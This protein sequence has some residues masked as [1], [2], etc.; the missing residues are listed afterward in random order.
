MIDAIELTWT[1]CLDGYEV[2]EVPT[3]EPAAASGGL[4]G[5]LVQTVGESGNNQ[6]AGRSLEVAP[7]S[8]EFSTYR[9]MEEVQRQSVDLVEEFAN[10]THDPLAIAG[11]YERFGPLR[12]P[13]NGDWHC[14]ESLRSWDE[15]VPHWEELQG[16]VRQ[17][18]LLLEKGSHRE[19]AD[20]FETGFGELTLRLPWQR[21]WDRP[22]MRLEPQDLATLIWL[23]AGRLVAGNSTVRPCKVCSKLMIIGGQ[24]GSYSNRET[25]SD[26]CRYAA[27]R[28]GKK[29]AKAG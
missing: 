10:T 21:A 6:S 1:R 11:F 16:N 4:L 22:I 28:A 24:T 27:Y 26:R 2:R 17:V 29:R 19:A 20:M 25:C 23:L 14:P 7:L 3:D 8:G 15:L 13:P 9:V 5:A 12:R 18:L